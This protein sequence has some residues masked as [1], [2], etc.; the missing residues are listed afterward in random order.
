MHCTVA[1]VLLLTVLLQYCSAVA[2]CCGNTSECCLNSCQLGWQCCCEEILTSPDS[3]L[4]S[5]DH[6]AKG[7]VLPLL[8]FWLAPTHSS[9]ELYSLLWRYRSD[10][11]AIIRVYMFIPYLRSASFSHPRQTPQPTN[12]QADTCSQCR[13]H[14]T[15]RLSPPSKQRE[16]S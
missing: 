12:P 5:H 6:H 2:I 11:A 3:R 10:S 13:V 4:V 1:V 9:L 8:A 7:F 14:D 16:S 15:I